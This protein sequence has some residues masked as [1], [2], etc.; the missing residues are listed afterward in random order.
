MGIKMSATIDMTVNVYCEEEALKI[1][2]D[3]SGLRLETITRGNIR[4]KNA[5][6]VSTMCRET[7]MNAQLHPEL[8]L[9]HNTRH[10]PDGKVNQE[11]LSPE[12]CH[13]APGLIPGLI[14]TSLHI[15]DKPP[16]FQR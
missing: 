16:Q 6:C 8:E 12:L 15:R 10:H 14:I 2:R 9:L 3:H 4:V 1:V 11:Q 7:L 13:L 5:T